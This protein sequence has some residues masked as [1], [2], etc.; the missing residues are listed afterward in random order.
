MCQVG[1]VG[2]TFVAELEGR[3][4][5]QRH[6]VDGRGVCGGFCFGGRS[7][8]SGWRVGYGKEDEGVEGIWFD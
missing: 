7:S 8:L 6:T 2:G 5:P 1:R 3:V 4:L